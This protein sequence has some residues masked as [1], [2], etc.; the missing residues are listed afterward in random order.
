MNHNLPWV[1]ERARLFRES[2]AGFARWARG[3]GPIVHKD[4]TQLRV[5]ELAQVLVA[6]GKA[7]DAASVYRT[8]W[9]ADRLAA[10]G[11]WLTVHMTYADRVYP[12]GR[13]MAA[14]DFKGTP[15]G[16]TGG[17]L[18]IVPAYVGYL[19]ANALSGLTR[20]WLMGQGHCV[21]GIDACNLLAG[22]MTPRHAERYDRSEGGLTRFARDFYSYAIDAAGR[23]ASPLGSHVGP[24][25]AGGL[26]EGGYLGFA[27]LQY[28]H[29]PLP[30][31]RLVVFLSDGAFEEQRGSDWAPRWWRAEDCGFVAPF[32]ILNGRRIEQ[33]STMQQQGGQEWFQQHLRLNGFDPMEIDGT[34]PAAFAWAVHA[35]EERLAA[36]AAAVASGTIQYPVPLHYTIAEAPKGFGFPGA[37]TNAAHNLPL[38]GNPHAD[39]SARQQFNEGARA[40][41]V[42]PAELDE[43]LAALCRHQDQQRP[44]ERDHPLAH[45]RV[46]APAL[47]AA[48]WHAVGT[49]QVSPMGALDAAFAAIVQA[50]PQLRPRVGNPDELRSNRMGQT[51]DLLKHRVFSPEPGLA[52]AVDGAVITALNE[53]AVVSAALGNKGGINLVVSYEA[54]AVKMLGALRQEILFARHQA[55]AGAPPGWLS[56]VTVATSHTWENGKNEQ[57]HQDPTLAEALLGEMSDTARVLFPVDA[58]SAA[59][60]LRAAYDTHGQFW[61]LVVPKRPMANR[62]T[63]EQAQRLVEE[64]ASV[65]KACEAPEVLLIAIGA[66]QLRQ[67]LLAADRLDA[68]GH[69]TAVTCIVEPG[70]FRT[71]RDERERAFVAGDA[72]LQQLFPTAAVARVLVSHMRPEPTLG[73]LRRID[74]GPQRTRALG[75]VARGGTLDVAGMLFANRCTWAHVAAEAASALGVDAAQVLRADELA[76]VR[77]Q[78]DPRTVMTTA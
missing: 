22:N 16:H 77:G 35:M 37:G 9:A 38:A 1:A 40:L 29:M 27:E 58:N 10:A 19:A 46:D 76:A 41:F 47:P 49:G 60:A 52:E 30:G 62:L 21:A 65:V 28:V 8:L 23:P 71:P 45:R 12:D 74:T 24:N 70:R 50:N 61:T 4:L 26:S 7:S 59:A 55:E 51:L 5:H 68:A 73:V 64:G 44:L 75:Y 3:F 2:D 18:N 56:V 17:S 15:E 34:D 6:G 36:C 32:M 67:A 48:Q 43:A 63:G 13:E 72:A 20:G 14:E 25:T 66:Y 11:M 39:P 57:S 53:E 69:R 31:E 33:R 78:G 54:F 42:P